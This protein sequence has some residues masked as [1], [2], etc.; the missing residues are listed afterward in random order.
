MGDL[1]RWPGCPAPPAPAEA[2]PAGSP[3]LGL[4]SLLEIML[5]QARS[6]RIVAGAV[7]AVTPDGNARYIWGGDPHRVGLVGA[8]A[9]LS[10]DL[11]G[12]IVDDEGDDNGQSA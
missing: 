4:V 1:I 12:Q 2:P 3:S 9:L 6:G 7:A 5:D 10:H 11:M 8:L